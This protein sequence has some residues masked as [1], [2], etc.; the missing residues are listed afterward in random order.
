MGKKDGMK[1]EP[2]EMEDEGAG[3]ELEVAAEDILTAVRQQ[4]TKNL[5]EALKNFIDMCS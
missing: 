3:E 2:E 5:A 1:E 4:N